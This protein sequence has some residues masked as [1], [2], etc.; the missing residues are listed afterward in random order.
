MSDW[1]PLSW[2]DYDLQQQPDYPDQAV[3]AKVCHELSG[4]PP[5]VTPA[6]V[7][8]LKQKLLEVR[9]GQR[10]ILHAGDCSEAFSDCTA[11]RIRR[12]VWLLNQLAVLLGHQTQKLVL[13]IGRI[14]G[15][16]AKPRSAATET[17]NNI[18][19]PAFRGEL[20]NAPE[21]T[22]AARTPDPHRM[23]RG[24]G[25]ASLTLNYIRALSDDL[26]QADLLND[27]AIPSE[28]KHHPT[29]GKRIRQAQQS[30]RWVSELGAQKIVQSPSLYTSHEAL[31]LRYES[32][33]TRQI[34][35][36]WYCLSTHLPWV[37]MRTATPQS[38][39]IEYLRGLANP[40]AIKVGPRMS[41][42]WLVKILERLTH[43]HPNRTVIL[44]H[45]FGAQKITQYLP[46]LLDV[47]EQHDF[48]AIWLCDPM[49][50]NTQT[51]VHHRKYR[52]VADIVREIERAIQ[53]HA[54]RGSRLH[55]LHL[56]TSADNVTE[57]IGGV[58]GI[59]HADLNKNYTTQVDPRLTPAQAMEVIIR[60]AE[61]WQQTFERQGMAS[62]SSRQT[63]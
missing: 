35:G 24:Y 61:R 29:L 5:L 47:T 19:L 30:L 58:S 7:E 1:H 20:V 4:L 45:R 23:V 32:A 55:G 27:E 56:E 46:K 9:R 25:L 15:Q 39:H 38:A 57:C 48:P 34:N 22:E 42:D 17:R 50:G 6:E 37:G 54:D 49:H 33:L 12:K 52:N 14:A 40:V 43:H 2:Q 13:T 59:R 10:L 63:K 26:A 16:Y 28:V 44:I 11:D 53:I 8:A 51:D 31:L 41:P 36:Q 60:F 62:L 21:F 3:L 18:S